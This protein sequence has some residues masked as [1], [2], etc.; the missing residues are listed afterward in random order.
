MGVAEQAGDGKLPTRAHKTP[1]T[2]FLMELNRTAHP[3]PASS[4]DCRGGAAWETF[5]GAQD[6][7]N[8]LFARGQPSGAARV[9]AAVAESLREQEIVYIQ[10]KSGP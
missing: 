6:S 4:I 2:L 1:A 9:Q 8:R 7:P 5:L 10:Q 3:P